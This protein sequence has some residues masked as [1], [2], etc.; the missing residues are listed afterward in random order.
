[1]RYD[2]ARRQKRIHLHFPLRL[3]DNNAI[4]LRQ[5]DAMLRRTLLALIAFAAILTARAGAQDK[6]DR[7]KLLFYTD[8]AGKVQPV[9]SIA[10]W[11]KRRASIMEA[12]QSI[13]G[14][15]PGKDKRC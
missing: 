14:P 13:M 4:P 5:G 9:K 10:D 2:L 12:M 8:G 1:M 15:L 7:D 3:L 6:L 11:E